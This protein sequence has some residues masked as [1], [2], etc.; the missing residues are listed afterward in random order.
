MD[1]P[2]D[3]PLTVRVGRWFGATPF[4]LLGLGVLLL[5][6]VAASITLWLTASGRPTG[7][8]ASSGRMTAVEDAAT[9]GSPYPAEDTIE[10]EAALGPD[11]DGVPTRPA[12]TESTAPGEVT[13][14]VTGAVVRPGLVVLETGG[15]VGDAVAAAGGL[16]D[17]AATELVNLARSLSDGEHVHVPREG[18]LPLPSTTPPSGTALDAP[19][20]DLNRATVDELQTLPGIGPAKAEAIVRHRETQGPYEVP[21]DLRAVPGIGEATF[22]RLAD[23]VT[24][25]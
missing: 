12:E 24:V 25:G 17:G 6:A 20:V 1:A 3:D 16:T 19:V 8:P 13:V 4:E 9:V 18:E 14:H 7:P 10:E 15:R 11:R 22:Q 5:G 2:P 21:G 23:L